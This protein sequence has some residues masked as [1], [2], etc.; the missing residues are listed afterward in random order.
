MAMQLQ[1]AGTDGIRFVLQDGSNRVSES[2]KQ[3]NPQ[4]YSRTDYSLS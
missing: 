2:A 4:S 3:Q 1:L